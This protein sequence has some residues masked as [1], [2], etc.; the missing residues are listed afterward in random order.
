MA[1]QLTI[2]G[3][4]KDMG[5]NPTLDEMQAAVGGWIE[6][7]PLTP[8]AVQATGFA[9]LYCNEEGKLQGLLPNVVAT[10]LAFGTSMID[11]IAG[12]VVLCKAN[13]EEEE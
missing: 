9:F 12:D 8:E 13:E 7:V 6:Y 3:E 2:E 5:H 1:Q 11:I 4:M 10:M